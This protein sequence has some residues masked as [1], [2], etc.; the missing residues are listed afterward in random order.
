MQKDRTHIK[1]VIAAGGTGGHLFPAQALALDLIQRDNTLRVTFMSPGLAKNPYFQKDHFPYREI[2]SAT[3]YK[4]N[5]LKLFK[6]L[7][8]LLRGTIQS[9]RH[10]RRIKPK[11]V[12]GFGSFHS[13]PVL[14]AA[15]LKGIP[16]IL[17]ESNAV[18][19][20]VNRLCS[21]FS[22]LTAIHFLRASKYLKGKTVCVRMPLLKKNESVT[23]AKAREYFKLDQD[24]LT[25]LIFG[26]SQGA[27]A[28]NRYF[29]ESLEKLLSKD[30]HF[31]VVHIVGNPERA[32]KLQQVYAKYQI[33]AS[34]KPFEEKMDFAWSAA[35]LSISRAGAATLA[36][37]IE[38]AIPGIL[39]PYPFATENH[40]GKNA[41]FVAEEIQGGVNLNECDLNADRLVSIIE[42]LLH[43]KHQKLKSMKRSLQDFKKSEEK[44][45]LCSVIFDA[46]ERHLG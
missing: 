1:I 43:S 7:F 38:F 40:Q 13:F 16:I 19:G 41:S 35:D 42:E 3:P 30:F 5:P 45:D 25:F 32:E 46:L 2:V 12:V 34:V 23:R 28:I 27:Q 6:S 26:G 37:Q 20:K 17:F 8:S 21:R 39:I 11:M 33:P 15:K 24:K 9:L 36:E 4:K 18:P 14:F 29:C 22:E 44:R 31:Q 10:L